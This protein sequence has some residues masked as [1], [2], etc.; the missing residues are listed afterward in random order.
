M[1]KQYRVIHLINDVLLLSSLHLSFFCTNFWPSNSR[2]LWESNK[3]TNTKKTTKKQQTQRKQWQ[4]QQKQQ[5]YNK[6]KENK[7]TNTHKENKK[8]TTNTNK[9]TV[10]HTQRKQHTYLNNCITVSAFCMYSTHLYYDI[11]YCAT[12]KN[13]F[14]IKKVQW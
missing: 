8:K 11:M 14:Y 2:D 3:A 13:W 12:I 10:E 9:T 7:T 4:R 6:H 1:D 5:Q